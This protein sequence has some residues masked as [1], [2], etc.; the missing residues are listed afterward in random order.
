MP[1]SFLECVSYCS[2]YSCEHRVALLFK[3]VR[4]LQK[5][6]S[7]VTA[8]AIE[9]PNSQTTNTNT[10]HEAYKKLEKALIEHNLC[11]AKD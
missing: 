9:S 5:D 6:S 8:A 4:L 11:Q 1:T 10:H 2:L 3:I 7:K